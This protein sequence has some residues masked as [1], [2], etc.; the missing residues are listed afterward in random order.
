MTSG[1]FRARARRFSVA[2]VALLVLHSL[3][4][5]AR[6]Q[7]QSEWVGTWATGPVL[8]PSSTGGAPPGP[9][10]APVRIHDQTARQ[11]IH[12]SIGG[13]ALRVAVT[14][15]FGSEPLDIGAA[16][17]ALRDG[18]ASIDTRHGAA[19][20]FAGAPS[21]TVAPGGM[22]VSDPVEMGVPALADLV[23][24]LYV[25]SDS[26]AGDG[27]TMHGTGLTT[28][29]V[30]P[31]G[32]HTGVATLPVDRT[33]QSWFYLSRV[34]VL[35]PAGTPVI[36]TLGDS[37][38]DGTASTPD[39]H[40]RWPDFLARRLVQRPGSTPPGVLNVGIGGNRVLSDNA[41]LGILR[42]DADGP[43]PPPP[44]PNALFG[45]SA[46]A[47][48]DRDVLAQPGVT[49]VIVLESTNDIGMAFESETPTVEEIIAG[50]MEL[51]ERVRARGLKVYGGTLAP[52]EG[53]FYFRDI[54]EVKRQAFNEWIRT[55]GAYDAVIDF[56]AAVRDPTN[57]GRIR[58]HYQSGDWLH[59]SDIGYRAMAQAIDLT[60]FD[61]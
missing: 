45:P 6:G 36:V 40:S 28:N 25:T 57:P 52:F 9:G 30:S 46:L 31:A 15:V 1:T 27:A 61:K 13:S 55:S 49:H 10:P 60:L 26:A 4:G 16:H 11:I 32:D 47:R 43:A 41:G 12:T 59:P 5:S 51:I 23:I 35:A 39:T 21:V 18:E 53:A 19:L 17:V 29:Y 42:R 38:T 37:I 24:D 56:D 7:G 20:L 8:L 48:L 44:H 54:G 22:V 50:H 2:W 58:E 3:A 14:N 34:D 33:F